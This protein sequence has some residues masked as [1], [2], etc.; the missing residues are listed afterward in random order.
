MNIWNKFFSTKKETILS[1]WCLS[2]SYFQWQMIRTSKI[3]KFSFSCFILF[4][5]SF[6]ISLSPSSINKSNKCLNF[7]E[8]KIMVNTNLFKLTMKMSR[9]FSLSSFSHLFFFDLLYLLLFNWYQY[10]VGEN[11]P[12]LANKNVTGSLPMI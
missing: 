12:T 4:I 5:T 3:T 2:S 7:E 1:I 6:V 10:L 8:L 11:T 9:K